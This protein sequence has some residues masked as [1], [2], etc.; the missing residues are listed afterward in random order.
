M[1]EIQ[2]LVGPEGAK[3]IQ[4]AIEGAHR[5]RNGFLTILLGLVP[6]FI[7]ATAAVSELK[8]ALNTIWKVGDDASCSAARGIFNV[9]IERFLSFALVLGASLFLLVSLFATAC[10][11]NIRSITPPIIQV[12]DWAVSFIAITLL[13]GF[14]L[15]ALP[16]VS[17]QWGDVA[18]GAVMT[19]VLFA[20]GKYALGVYLGS[21]GFTDT[22]GAAASLVILLVWVYY[23]AQVLFFGAEFTRVYT[24]RYGSMFVSKLDS[25]VRNAEASLVP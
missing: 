17:L 23:S 20:A 5:P 1:L 10:I 15:K 22:Y 16:K 24:Q 25:T 2:G 11:S 8:S 4:G 7:G 6:L 12:T 9:I 3:V 14:I 19:S 21:A 18:F 13:F